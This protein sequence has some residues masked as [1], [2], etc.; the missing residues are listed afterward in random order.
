MCFVIRSCCAQ[1]HFKL[2]ARATHSSVLLVAY[3]AAQAYS[4]YSLVPRKTKAEPNKKDE[5]PGC[6]TQILV[7]VQKSK[8]YKFYVTY[9]YPLI[10]IGLEIFKITSQMLAFVDYAFSVPTRFARIQ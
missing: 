3:L 1:H 4:I 9:R 5:K 6:H 8:M 2:C 10:P 7:A